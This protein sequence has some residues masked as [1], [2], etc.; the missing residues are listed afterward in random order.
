MTLTPSIPDAPGRFPDTPRFQLDE[1]IATLR[2]NAGAWAEVPLTRKIEY[3]A[4]V[5]RRWVE[6]GDDLVADAVASKGVGEE[7]AGED[8]AGG[9]LAFVR[10]LRLLEETLRSIESTGAVPIDDDDIR[11]RPDGQVT[12]QVMPA[13]VWDRLVYLG[14]TAEVWLDPDVDRDA[15]R[16]HMGGIYTKPETAAQGVA[17]VLGAGNH[18]SIAPLDVVNELF[19]EGWVVLL[20]YN[21]VNDYIGP[22]VEYAFEE[23]IRAG[24]VRCV[25][26]GSEVGDY[27]AHHEGIDKV[28]ITGSA[29]TFEIIVFG[30]GEE[31]ADRKA[32]NDPILDKPITGELGNVSPTIV[33]P[34]RWS[35]RGLRYHAEHV[36]TQMM[37]NGGFNCTAAKLLVLPSR[38]EQKQA[39]LAE[40]RRVLLGLSD[41][42]AWYPG[43]EE[44]FDRFVGAHDDV[45]LLGPRARGLVPPTFIHDVSTEGGDIALEEEAFCSLA[46]VAELDVADPSEYLDA[47]VELCNERVEGTL[48][49]T[50]LIDPATEREHAGAL[51]RAV[52]ALR[53]GTVGIN[54]WASSGF[55]V[56]QTPWGGFPGATL[57]DVQS[58]IGWVHNAYLID[59]PQ[60]TVIRSPFIV[61]PKPPWFVTHRNAT[62][63]MRAAS[64]FDGHPTV[65]G[66]VKLFAQALRA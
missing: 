5:R 13:D 21:P 23:L 24:L 42:P 61:T 6:I 30:E 20:K 8:W 11:V 66:L 26:G 39:F 34:G 15:V 60:K 56:G 57:D 38:W 41:R 12:V 46:A 2:S 33:V 9:V 53:Y 35:G 59:R 44:R 14:W 27:L 62:K 45:E 52:A 19:T 49:A 22:Y 7:L 29:R 3:L 43:T 1:A 51:D 32:R 4:E 18:A 36:A 47:A 55:V 25:Y 58:G 28:H 10:T 40:L 54:V 37:Q 63:T 17:L 31:G 50:I 65:F 16:D 48:I 64:R